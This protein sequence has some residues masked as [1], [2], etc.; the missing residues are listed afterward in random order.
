MHSGCFRVDW[1]GAEGAYCRG[2]AVASCALQGCW[3]FGFEASTFK[4]CGW[5]VESGRSVQLSQQSL[6]WVAVKG[7]EEG[8]DCRTT[9]MFFHRPHYLPSLDHCCSGPGSL[10]RSADCL[11]TAAAVASPHAYGCMCPATSPTMHP[12]ESVL[13]CRAHWSAVTHCCTITPP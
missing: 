3:G 7:G 9:C 10:P 2:L 8:R 1:R 4:G 5:V 13:L 11:C 12:G 6:H